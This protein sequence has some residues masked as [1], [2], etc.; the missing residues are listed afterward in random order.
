MPP[1]ALEASRIKGDPRIVPDDETKVAMTLAGKQRLVIPV[2]ICLDEQGTPAKVEV[3]RPSG[4]S[5]Y[6]AKIEATML[7]WR[8][9]PFL[10][11]GVASRVCSAVTFVYVQH[12][13]VD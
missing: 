12:T 3:L 6:D 13:G 4:F 5:A 11:N 2:K 7:T 9:S 8:Y 10:V 1:R